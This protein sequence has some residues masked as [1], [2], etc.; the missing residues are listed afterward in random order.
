MTA[1]ALPLLALF[2]FACNSNVVNAPSGEFNAPGGIAATGAGDRDLLFIANSG[3][4]SLRALQLCNAPLLADGGL[5]PATPAPPTRTGS[6]F[7]PPSASSPP[8]S[9]PGI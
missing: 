5:P 8:P 2:A 9:R 7:P 1:R 3:R 6:S 4:D